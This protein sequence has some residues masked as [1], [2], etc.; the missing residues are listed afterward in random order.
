MTNN[1]A[2]SIIRKE[3]LC[4]DRDCDIERSCGKC[5]LVMPSKEPILQAYKMAIKAL[6]Q[7]QK[8]VHR[9]TLEQVMWERN[10]AIEQ[11]KELGYGFGE[12]P[13]TGHW[14]EKDG[15]DG[16]TYYDCSECGES[17][18]TIEGTPWNNGMKYCPNC[19]CRMVEPQERR[20]IKE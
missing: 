3:Y 11:L 7:E 15:F 4:V 18:T 16:D 2:V 13:K 12:K 8:M 6:E 9:E 19:G 17:W 20:G 1:E 10:V 14:I 5:D